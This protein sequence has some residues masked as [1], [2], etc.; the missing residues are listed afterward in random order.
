[1]FKLFRN[2]RQKEEQVDELLSAH[3]DGALTP[4]EQAELE[5]RLE[6]EPELQ[7]RR[8]GLRQTVDALANLPQAEP[9]RNF[10]LSPSMVSAPAA[11][12]APAAPAAPRRR[13]SWLVMSWATTAATLLL[14]IILA[15]D[16]FVVAPS[17]RQEPSTIIAQI[18]S[19]P[20]TA[21]QEDHMVALTLESE[22]QDTAPTPQ[23]AVEEK[24]MPQAA[25]PVEAPAEE[26]EAIVEQPASRAIP[27]ADGPTGE[28]EQAPPAEEEPAPPQLVPP[29]AATSGALA[30]AA[31]PETSVATPTPEAIA[32]TPTDEVEPE[33]A[34]QPTLE[35]L[36][37]AE[38]PTYAMT[39]TA[40]VDDG[41]QD[42][43]FSAETGNDADATEPPSSITPTATAAATTAGVPLWL[44]GLELALGLTV[45]ALAAATWIARRRR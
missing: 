31:A 18:T 35:L 36:E 4:D 25:A 45:V 42:M 43:T 16:I 29:P 21:P 34:S 28:A 7:A 2:R 24:E 1:M 30:G 39:F 6:L 19:E 14:I 33:M 27:Q 8:E 13:P 20:A 37:M 9:P 22:E 12:A 32:A 10:I 41:Q 23:Q 26:T 38:T 5:T 17:A 3:L 15:G 11:S 40:K 44:R